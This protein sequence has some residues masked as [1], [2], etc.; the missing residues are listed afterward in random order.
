[1]KKITIV[2]IASLI[3]L[4]ICSFVGWVF[5]FVSFND[6]VAF[7]V[8]G[9]VICLISGILLYILRKKGLIV[10]LIFYLINAFA[11]G[12]RI[13]GWYIFRGFD[14]SIWVMLLISLISSLYL[15]VF[16][17]FLLIPFFNENYTAFAIIFMILSIIAYIIVIATTKTTYISTYGWYMIIEIAFLFAISV[18]S[19]NNQELFKY[20]VI[21]TYSVLVV[22]IIMLLIMLSGD[23]FDVP[24]DGFGGGDLSSPRKKATKSK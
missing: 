15:L 4:S 10:Y 9:I 18:K 13:R 7:V 24:L 20:A 12:L 5:R 6:P 3:F 17:L 8:I 19:E 23:G 22:G 1:M 21:S 2:S 14:N 11:L 16:Y